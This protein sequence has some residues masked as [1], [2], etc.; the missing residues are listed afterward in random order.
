[1]WKLNS[2]IKDT[3]ME[4]RFSSLMNRFEGY[5]TSV[6]NTNATDEQLNRLEAL[7]VRIENATK[8]DA[9]APVAIVEEAKQVAA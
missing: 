3:H 4:N 5:V 2:L 8:G 9:K 7:V 6:E 1:M